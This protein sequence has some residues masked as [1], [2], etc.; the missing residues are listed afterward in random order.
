MWMMRLVLAVDK[1]KNSSR[2]LFDRLIEIIGTGSGFEMLPKAFQSDSSPA[3]K[4]GA[5]REAVAVQTG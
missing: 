1:I 5:T 4:A 2:E 3:N